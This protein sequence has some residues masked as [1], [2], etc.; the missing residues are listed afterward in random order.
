MK[1]FE[2]LRNKAFWSVD[3]V[4][5]GRKRKHYDE[6][7]FIIENPGSSKSNQLRDSYLKNIVNHAVNSTDYFKSFKN[8]TSIED[9]HVVNKNI[10]RDNFKDFQSK[11]Y[12]DKPKFVMATSGSTGMPFKIYHNSNKRLRNAA[13]TIFFSEKA[14]F[15]IGNKLTYFRL[16]NAFEKKNKLD[17]IL[18]NIKPVDVFDLQDES[19]IKNVLNELSSSSSSNSWLGYASAY[20]RICKYLDHTNEYVK[21]NKLRSSIAM[22][23]RLN[24]YTKDAM[25]THFGADVV[26]RYSNIEN[27]I[28]AQQPLGNKRYFRINDASY[29]VEILEL[30]TNRRVEDGKPGRIVITDLFNY[31]MPMIRYDTGDIGIKGRIG[32]IPI[33]KEISGR[34]YDLI[35]DTK[36]NAIT[37]NLGLL[38]NNYP[39]LKQFQF[40]QK[41]PKNYELRINTDHD[42]DSEQDF[43]NDFKTYLGEDANI[44][45]SYINEIPLLASG[46]RRVLINEMFNS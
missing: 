4:T 40:I 29:Y 36:G 19:V 37:L 22:S 25:L 44:K 11:K 6:I 26:S 23:E 28:I 1:P 38:V 3:A 33:F 35:Y 13:D 2:L 43:V 8:Y 32:N 24:D 7:K 21:P 41:T 5:G 9:F 16:W 17:R 34:K 30:N 12:L 27:G 18:Q 42:F 10:I 39:T 20:E 15:T 14:G 46:K 45:V 31:Y